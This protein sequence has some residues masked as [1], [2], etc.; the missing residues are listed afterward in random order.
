MKKYFLLLAISV[1]GFTK[2]FAQ[3]YYNPYNSYNYAI[4]AQ[5][6]YDPCVQA[7]I[8]SAQTANQIYQQS[9]Q[10]QMNLIQNGFYN[11]NQ[12]AYSTSSRNDSRQIKRTTYVECDNCNGRGYNTRTVWMGGSEIRTLKP[13]CA[14]CHGTGK[15]R[16]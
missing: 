9:Y 3:Y 2:G 10:Y 14:Y 12:N 8:R 5:V 16:R 6:F 11:Q 15:V 13:R 4:S 7:T 1:I